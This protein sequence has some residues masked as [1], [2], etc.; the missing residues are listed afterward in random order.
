MMKYMYIMKFH[1]TV[2]E[3]STQFFSLTTFLIFTGQPQLH[4]IHIKIVSHFNLQVLQS[5]SIHTLVTVGY[6]QEKVL[7]MVFLIKGSHGC[8][9]WWDDVV[10]KK[11]EGIL[12]SKMN[13]FPDEEVELTDS[14]IRWNQILLLVQVSNTSFWSFLNNHRNTIGILLANFLSLSTPLLKWVLFFVVP[15]HDVQR[16]R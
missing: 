4:D 11:E 15:L 14:Q 9:C 16:F 10:D 6:V 2:M 8:R 1:L 3:P 13:S 7:F 12:W 5:S